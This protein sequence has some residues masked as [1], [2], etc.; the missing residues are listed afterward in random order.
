VSP[1]KSRHDRLA[2]KSGYGLEASPFRME[3]AFLP[4]LPL[5]GKNTGPTTHPYERWAVAT[6]K[7][8]TARAC[9]G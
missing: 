1:I 9:F 4:V 8:A 7:T 6:G 3:P 2:P 5:A